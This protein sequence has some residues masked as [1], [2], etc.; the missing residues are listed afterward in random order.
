MDSMESPKDFFKYD[1]VPNI[2]VQIF[3]N[4]EWRYHS[5]P[6]NDWFNL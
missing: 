5:D 6:V 1:N 2:E 4:G 3:K